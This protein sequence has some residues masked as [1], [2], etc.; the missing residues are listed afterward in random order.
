[1]SIKTIKSDVLKRIYV[2]REKKMRT[3][4]VNDKDSSIKQNLNIKNGHNFVILNK[5]LQV[6]S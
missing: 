5:I 2:L 1:M 3:N 4:L 6:L